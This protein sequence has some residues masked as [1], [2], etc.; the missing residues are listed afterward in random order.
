MRIVAVLIATLAFALGL[1]MYFFVGNGATIPNDFPPPQLGVEASIEP[2]D[3]DTYICV[4]TVTDLENGEVIAGPTLKFG[5]GEE[6]VVLVGT[7]DGERQLK[8]QVLA[9]DNEGSA[10]F[11]LS[12]SRDGA[13][14]TVVKL[15]LRLTQDSH[16]ASLEAANG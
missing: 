6:A 7:N 13:E 11:L 8:V 2:S 12:V 9:D 16:S 3:G 10:R 5:S 14:L 1:A 15:S 4:A